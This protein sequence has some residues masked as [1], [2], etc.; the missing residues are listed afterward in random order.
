MLSN[1]RAERVI[2]AGTR[3]TTVKAPLLTLCA[4]VIT[5]QWSVSTKR[6]QAYR[7]DWKKWLVGLF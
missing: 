4:N 6:Q 2:L 5:S 1:T 7:E 3:R